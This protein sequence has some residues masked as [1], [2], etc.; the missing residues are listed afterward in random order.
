MLYT[1][2]LTTYQVIQTQIVS[3]PE[4]VFDSEENPLSF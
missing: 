3:H 1:G 2:V 4:Q